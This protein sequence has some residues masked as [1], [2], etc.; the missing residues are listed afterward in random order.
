M[1]DRQPR[2][3]QFTFFDFLCLQVLT[4]QPQSGGAPF[5]AAY[6]WEAEAS[7][8]FPQVEKLIPKA[9]KISGYKKLSAV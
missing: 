3:L 8:H 7:C 1:G 4:E 5:P 9:P 6:S 2:I